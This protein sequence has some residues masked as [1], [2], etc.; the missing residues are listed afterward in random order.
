MVS[1]LVT[2]C[3]VVLSDNEIVTLVP[4]TVTLPAIWSP[5]WMARS[6][7]VSAAGTSSYQA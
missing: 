4:L 1:V 3:P 6:S 7:F 5:G 2:D